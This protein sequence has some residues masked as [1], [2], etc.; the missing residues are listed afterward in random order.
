MMKKKLSYFIFVFILLWMAVV[1]GFE[2]CHYYGVINDENTAMMICLFI[3]VQAA[4]TSDSKAALADRSE[5]V[6]RECISDVESDKQEEME[7]QDRIRDVLMKNEEKIDEEFA[8]WL[9]EH[10]SEA[11]DDLAA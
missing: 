3:G 5:K 8:G 2:V 10:Y 7:E 4:E 1:M 9:C 6:T 11:C